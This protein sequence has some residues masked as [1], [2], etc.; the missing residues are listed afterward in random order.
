MIPDEIIRRRIPP[1][2]AYK[3]PHSD[4]IGQ[5]DPT[6]V[7]TYSAHGASAMLGK[8]N[9]IDTD[10]VSSPRIE[11][12]EGLSKLRKVTTDVFPGRY[13]RRIA[14]DQSAIA[15]EVRK[16]VSSNYVN[17]LGNSSYID[18]RRRLARFSHSF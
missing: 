12:E 10:T 11:G 14:S 5:Q 13:A 1:S 3:T 4:L 8:R 9:G 2:F 18:Y 15:D 16:Y 17:P 7:D 6:S